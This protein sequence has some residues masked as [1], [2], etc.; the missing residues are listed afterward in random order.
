MPI[1]PSESEQEYF[2]RLEIEK[3]RAAQS[4]ATAKMQDEERRRTKELHWMK[5]PKCGADLGEVAYRSVRIDV[6]GGCGGA[7]L[8]K[9]E[10]EQ[11][12]QLEGGESVF[13]RMLKA[14]KG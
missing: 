5:C 7:F 10:I 6:C 4:E 13:G 3:L 11:L 2:L 1:N 8:D 9:G 14:F 12:L